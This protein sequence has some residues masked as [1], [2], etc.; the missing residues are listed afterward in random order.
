MQAP[1]EEI[2]DREELVQQGDLQRPSSIW[3]QMRDP[4]PSCEEEPKFEIDL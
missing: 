4:E 3:K 2:E 1:K